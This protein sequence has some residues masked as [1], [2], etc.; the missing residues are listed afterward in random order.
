VLALCFTSNKNIYLQLYQT[1][2]KPKISSL[3]R[4]ILCI[5]QKS[6]LTLLE[7]V[8]CVFEIGVGLVL[9]FVG[10]GLFQICLCFSFS[11]YSKDHALHC[12]RVSCQNQPIN[13]AIALRVSNDITMQHCEVIPLVG[14]CPTSMEEVWAVSKHPWTSTSSSIWQTRGVEEAEP[15]ALALQGRWWWGGWL[16]AGSMRGQ[17]VSKLFIVHQY[18]LPSSTVVVIVVSHCYCRELLLSWVAA[19]ASRRHGHKLPSWSWQ[20]RRAACILKRRVRRA[21]CILMYEGAASATFAVHPVVW[22][23][24][25]CSLWHASWCIFV[26]RTAREEEGGSNPTLVCLPAYLMGLPFH[27]LPAPNSHPKSIDINL[28]GGGLHPLVEGRGQRLMN[29]GVGGPK[30]DEIG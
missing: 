29:L 13:L 2:T 5:P 3:L 25:E 17:C 24:S 16:C 11:P 8:I 20:V 18:S 12:W 26:V 7:H 28:N 4:S 10:F 15:L 27:F 1:V 6:P 23:S 19:V 9:V 30:N 21:V 14:S 22:G